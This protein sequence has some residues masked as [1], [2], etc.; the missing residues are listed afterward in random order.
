MNTIYGISLHIGHTPD[1]HTLDFR[2]IILLRA[3]L[4]IRLEWKNPQTE[5]QEA[6]LLGCVA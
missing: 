3:A 6:C 4:P 5:H 2:N 1:A